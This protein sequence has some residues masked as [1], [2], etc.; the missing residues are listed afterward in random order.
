MDENGKH[1]NHRMKLLCAAQ[2]ERR[3]DLSNGNPVSSAM[4][5]GMYILGIR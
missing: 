2:I 5:H 1:W 4:H 3:R